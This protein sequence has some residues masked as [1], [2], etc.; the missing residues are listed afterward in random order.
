MKLLSAPANTTLI[1]GF[2]FR[3]SG[4]RFYLS[5]Y[6]KILVA[7]PL[8]S[9]DFRLDLVGGS[10]TGMG[11]RE[12]GDLKGEGEP[13]DFHMFFPPKLLSPAEA[14]CRWISAL[15]PHVVCV[16]IEVNKP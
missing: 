5:Y 15:T 8:R 13:P 14:D 4:H 3:T 7:R 16:L 2:F 6:V 1:W 12:T 11:K 10:K 9:V